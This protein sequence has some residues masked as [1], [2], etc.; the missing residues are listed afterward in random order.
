MRV[1]YDDNQ[2]VCER[3]KVENGEAKENDSYRAER[4][5]RSHLGSSSSASSKL[6]ANLNLRDPPS[7][8]LAKMTALE[9]KAKAAATKAML[10]ENIE[11]WLI[12]E[13]LLEMS[14]VALLAKLEEQVK[15]N[16]IDAAI[17]ASVTVSLKE[18]AAIAKYWVICRAAYDNNNAPEAAAS[19]TDGPIPPN[20]A[21][22]VKKAWAGR[23]NIV[24]P[25]AYMAI[26]SIQGKIWRDA[27]AD[28]PRVTVWLAES[29]RTRSCLDKSV[30]HLLSVVPGKV[31]ET[32]GVVADNVSK[33]FELYLRIRCFFMTLSYV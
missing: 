7:L 12:A 6:A 21:A 32:I 10:T 29:L 5:S 26:E 19:S 31:A 18:K 4:L 11:K 22:D 13:G 30:G 27:T 25:D 33:P 8:S 17:A 2:T 28:P 23:H 20:D 14:D 3:Q 16:I 1:C 24:L 9:V 15:P